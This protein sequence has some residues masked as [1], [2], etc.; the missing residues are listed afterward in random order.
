MTQIDKNT[1][2]SLA[3][4]YKRLD[5]KELPLSLFKSNSRCNLVSLNGETIFNSLYLGLKSNLKNNGKYLRHINPYSYA[6]GSE[7]TERPI[8]CEHNIEI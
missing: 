5:T 6:N 4:I 2:H 7:F 1:P 8:K 3:S